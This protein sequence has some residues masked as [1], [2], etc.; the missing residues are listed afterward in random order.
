MRFDIL[1]IFP[2]FFAG[3]IGGGPFS[4]G[5]LKRAISAGLVSVDVHNLRDWAEGPHRQVDD[6]PYG[7]GP[8]MVM[9]V[10]PICRAIEAIRAMAG[11]PVVVLLS[12]QGRLFDQA[13]AFRYQAAGRLV[14]ICGRYEG[15]DRRVADRLADEE[16][17]VG[18]FVL[19]GGEIAALNVVESVSRLVPGAT[20]N[21]E[22][23]QSESFTRGLLDYPQYTRPADFNGWRVPE[24]LLSGHHARIESWRADAALELTRRNRPDLYL[25]VAGGRENREE[26]P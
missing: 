3:P 12:A 11:P 13:T 20:G 14:L 7:G 26:V 1:T 8:G 16:L 5:L 18:D 9:K 21:P 15:V 6:T 2:E 23:V 22:S 4:C 17:S 25:R 10:E 24:E 19:A